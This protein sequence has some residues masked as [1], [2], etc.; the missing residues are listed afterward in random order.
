MKTGWKLLTP[1]RASPFAPVSVKYST[2]QWAEPKPGD[3]PL[4]VFVR[5]ATLIRVH[6]E[7]LAR[8]APLRIW[9]VT[10]EPWDEPLQMFDGRPV[11][12][13]CRVGDDCARTTGVP[14]GV[15]LAKR[16]KL[17]N[18]MTRDELA[19]A[20]EATRKEVDQEATDLRFLQSL[21]PPV[22]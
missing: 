1:G 18:E 21:Y 7:R 3:G 8:P 5:L 9:T 17:V 15:A 11:S 19:K 12:G 16:V 20:L 13:W 14:E 22:G 6:R 2:E 4:M 10:F